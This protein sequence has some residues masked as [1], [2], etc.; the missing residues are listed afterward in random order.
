MKMLELSGVCIRCE[1]GDMLAEELIFQIFM[2]CYEVAV[3]ASEFQE[4][5]DKNKTNSSRSS[6]SN[7]KTVSSL[8]STTAG[9]TLAHIVLVLF[10]R[11]KNE[12]L[13]SASNDK[14]DDVLNWGGDSDEDDEKKNSS[15]TTDENEKQN[16]TPENK[17]AI[18][19][20]MEHLSKLTNPRQYNHHYCSLALSLINIA[21]ETGTTHLKRYANLIPIMQVRNEM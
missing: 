19:R 13:L 3:S 8:L 15:A 10:N 5:I 7:N 16:K 18:V 17:K 14:D 1:V 11:S 4:P 2:V 6:N 20:I 21:L 9:N 12:A